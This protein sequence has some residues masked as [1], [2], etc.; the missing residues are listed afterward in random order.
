MPVG[1]QTWIV[2]LFLNL[3]KCWLLL[4]ITLLEM[5]NLDRITLWEPALWIL[6]HDAW[7]RMQVV[8]QS[9]IWGT[10]ICSHQYFCMWKDIN[11]LKLLHTFCLQ[12]AKMQDLWNCSIHVPC[13]Y[14][15]TLAN[16]Q[17]KQS[18]LIN[19]HSGGNPTCRC[20]GCRNGHK[21]NVLSINL[22][23]Q[24]NARALWCVIQTALSSLSG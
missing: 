9:C 16:L 21:R 18:R 7:E 17:W 4:A 19:R 24:M 2:N 14:I 23:K 3:G 6:R 15:I 1:N 12:D 13:K 8:F 10:I 22:L 5:N 20:E 11:N